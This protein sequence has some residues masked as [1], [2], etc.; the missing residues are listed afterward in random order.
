M[1]KLR[2]G[3]LDVWATG[4]DDRMGGGS[5]PAI[6]LCHGFGAPGDD[7][8]SLAR[9]IDVG[10][11]V[12]WFFPEAPLTIDFGMGQRGRAWWPI[13]MERLLGAVQGGRLEELRKDTPD[14]LKKARAALEGALDALE[15]SHG[16]RRDKT[17]LG[18]FSQGGMIATEIAVHAFDRPFA[19]LAVLSGTLLSE[20]RWDAALARNGKNIHAIVAHG[21]RDP[22]LPFFGSEALRD[23]L[24]KHGAT[25]T[26]VPHNGMHEI[27]NVA[28]EALAKLAKERL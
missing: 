18:G 10:R 1:K 9:V 2:M 11:D 25:V 4:G 22:V 6:A 26:F 12:R 14:G 13:D 28:L 3:E 17:I 21:R 5:G 15:S 7:L 8:V 16:V 19:G 27:P 24:T 20:E 23:L